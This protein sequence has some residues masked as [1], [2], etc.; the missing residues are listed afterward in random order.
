MSDE[1]TRTASWIVGLA[2]ADGFV[3][4]AL[5]SQAPRLSASPQLLRLC[6]Q[7]VA[8]IAR[9]LRRLCKAAADALGCLLL[10]PRRLKPLL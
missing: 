8:R 1:K 10:A 6:Y 2:K 4:V 3:W 9:R 5:V 7:Q